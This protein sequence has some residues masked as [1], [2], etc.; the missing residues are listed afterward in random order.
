MIKFDLRQKQPR[1]D[2]KTRVNASLDNDTH[3]KLKKLAISC[4]MTKTMLAAELLKM[5]V[6]HLDIID[7]YQKNYNKND[8]YR[9]IPVKKDG[10]VLY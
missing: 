8:Q 4:D 2:K 7:F 10:K 3:E 1:S 5:C 6:N 9:V